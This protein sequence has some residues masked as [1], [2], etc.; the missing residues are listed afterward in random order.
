MSQS[1]TDEP[2][3]PGSGAA[4]PV[5]EPPGGALDR[6]LNDEPAQPDEGGEQVPVDGKAEPPD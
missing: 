6:V 2:E 4:K 5:T 1:T 3:G